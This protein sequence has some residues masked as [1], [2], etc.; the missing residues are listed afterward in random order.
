MGNI[1]MPELK[2]LHQNNV[3]STTIESKKRIHVGVFWIS[4][5]QKRSGIEGNTRGPI[6]SKNANFLL[7]SYY[8]P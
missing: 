2:Y 8:V 6:I 1:G 4:I 7:D 3:I 5:N